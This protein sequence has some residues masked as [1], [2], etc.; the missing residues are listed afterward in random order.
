[1][2]DSTMTV[3][4]SLTCLASLLAPELVQE[5]LLNLSLHDVAVAAITCQGWNETA[6]NILWKDVNLVDL[7]NVLA[8]TEEKDE[9]LV[10]IRVSASGQCAIPISERFSFPYTTAFRSSHHCGRL[11]T[12]SK[13]SFPDP[14]RNAQKVAAFFAR[15]RNLLDGSSPLPIPALRHSSKPRHRCQWQLAA[16]PGPNTGY[17]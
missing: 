17:P 8:P 15:R 12:L 6:L 7:L 13:P 16:F 4:E 11:V 14:D 10:S 3:H 2:S 5:I 1:M 9:R